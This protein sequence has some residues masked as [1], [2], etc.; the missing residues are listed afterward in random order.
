MRI[1]PLLELV[2]T[3][4][5]GMAMARWHILD[6]TY[7]AANSAYSWSMWAKTIAETFLAGAAVVGFI[8]VWIERAFRRGPR[9][10][11]IGRC[12]WS[13]VGLFLMLRVAF[14]SANSAVRY[15]HFGKSMSD[16][17]RDIRADLRVNFSFF[18]SMRCPM[19]CSR[20]G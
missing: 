15:R 14:S 20:R 8:G 10:W 4:A 9:P 3:L 12:A 13:L 11:G 16:L 5:A 2:A 1:V 18:F 7:R 17:V 6:P 19:H